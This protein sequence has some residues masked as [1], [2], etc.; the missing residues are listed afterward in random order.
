MRVDFIIFNTPI[1]RVMRIELNG[2]KRNSIQNKS[3]FS[4]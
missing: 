1:E 4:M 3:G 2:I